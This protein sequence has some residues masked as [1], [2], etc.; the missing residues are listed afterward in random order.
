M[1]QRDHITDSLTDMA[2]QDCERSMNLEI[3]N[4]WQVINDLVAHLSQRPY[5]RAVMMNVFSPTMLSCKSDL[6]VGGR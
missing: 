1:L 3:F 2:N 4:P 6:D 5:V